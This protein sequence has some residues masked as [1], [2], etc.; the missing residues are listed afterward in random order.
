MSQP[1][2][3]PSGSQNKPINLVVPAKALK[4][5]GAD[6]RLKESFKNI[7]FAKVESIT[8]SGNSYGFEACQWIATNVLS[9]T[10]NIKHIDFSDIFTT[11]LRNTLPESLKVLMAPL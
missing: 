4:F 8:L 2:S 5:D 7:D 9:K 1:G 6:D 11:R 3:A 10:T